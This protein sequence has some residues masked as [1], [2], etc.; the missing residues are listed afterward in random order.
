VADLGRAVEWYTTMLG[1]EVES[2]WP[3]ERPNPGPGRTLTI[4]YIRETA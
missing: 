4:T 3:P 2:V 1:F